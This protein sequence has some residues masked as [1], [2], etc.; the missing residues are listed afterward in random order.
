MTRDQWTALTLRQALGLLWD[1]LALGDS[2][3][4]VEPPLAPRPP[5]FDSRINGKDGFVWASEA[6]MSALRR[7]HARALASAAKGGEWAEKDAKAAKA[8][9]YWIAWREVE[10][11]TPWHGER[12]RFEVTARPPSASPAI[13]KYPPRGAA[14]APATAPAQTTV[15]FDENG[16]SDDI[17]F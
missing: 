5:K 8:Y 14:A 11:S 16:L 12:N 7:A 9:S 4:D 10:P 15:D 13:H 2:L 1:H 17:P 6:D 3:G